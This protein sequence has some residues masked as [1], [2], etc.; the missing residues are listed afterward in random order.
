MKRIYFACLFVCLTT[1]FLLS[2]S[3][4]VPAPISTSQA[5]PKA[6]AKILDQYGKL[7]LSFE[8]NHGQTDGRVKFLSRTGG[9]TLFLTG[10]EA[11]LALSG[12]KASTKTK[13]VGKA[14]TLHSDTAPS[15]AGGVLRMKLR[16]ANPAAKVSGVDELAGKSN[17]F[18][19]NDPAKWRT[20][21]PTYAKVKY[22]GIYSGIDLVYYG[23]QRQLEY[24]FVVAPGANPRRIQFDVRG[25]KRIRQDGHGELVFKVGEDQICWH[26]PLVYQEKDGARQELSLIHI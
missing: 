3:N 8:A 23:N 19:G 18:I 6:Q 1:T 11:V 26:K 9:Y 13:V 24:D 5:D 21:V 7:P 10:D 2:Q 20:N 12:K 14:R 15:K 25:A 22:E 4:P 16:N 17:Y